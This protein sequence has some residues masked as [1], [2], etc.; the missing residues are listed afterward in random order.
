M[1]NIELE[2]EHLAL[3]DRHI[4]EAR[5]NITLMEHLVESFRPEDFAARIGT[6]KE[7]LAAFEAHRALIVET[8]DG[9]RN[10]SLPD[11]TDG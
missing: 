5:D 9:V 4:A 3:A 6:L 10:G 2:R 7:T 11:R 8:L 1:P